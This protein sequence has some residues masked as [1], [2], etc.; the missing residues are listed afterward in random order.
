M[1]KHS[2]VMAAV[3]ALPL[4]SPAAAPRLVERPALLVLDKSDN[5]MA[6]IDL[7]SR[8]I[9]AR[10]PVGAAP[11]EVVTSEDGAWAFV[12][13]Y[14]DG[15]NPGHTISV[16]DLQNLRE[17]RKVD[18]APLYRPH[19]LAWAGGKLY[20][21]SET[22]RAV[23]RYDPATNAVDWIV[24]TGQTTT[25]MVAASRDGRTLYTANIGGNSISVLQ[26]GN[27]P[28]TAN[29]TSI[30]VGRGPEGF[31]I[32]PDGTELWAAHSQDGGVS[33]IDLATKTVVATIDAKTGRSNRCKFTPDGGTVL[34]SDLNNN[35]LVVI[36]VKSRQVTGR[37]ATGKTPLGILMDPDGSTAYVAFSEDNQIGVL[38]L[39]TLAFTA[40]IDTGKTPDGMALLK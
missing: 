5:D 37:I 31:D 18:T 7:K 30:P 13:N 4:W 19:G 34:I 14:G 35:Q 16:I 23:A 20:F 22:S 26:L 11:H 38:D 10:I 40:R 2:I 33:V 8:A 9:T 39:K 12:A 1:L 6:V 28:I 21:T 27:S 15:P 36:D 24:G 3:S 17:V 29:V 25:H 32:S